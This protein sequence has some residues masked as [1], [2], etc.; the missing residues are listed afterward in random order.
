MTSSLG[1][2]GADQCSPEEGS[3]FNE[4]KNDHGRLLGAQR[5]NLTSYDGRGFLAWDPAGRSQPSGASD[6]GTL[7]ADLKTHVASAGEFGCGFE[8]QLEAW[9]RFLIDPE[10]PLEV[11]RAP[12]TRTLP[13][14]R[15]W[16]S[17]FLPS[18]QTFSGPI[19]PSRSS[20]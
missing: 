11:I 3:T 17:K 1:G 15:A 6:L 7:I 8:S 13:Y 2:H 12:T 9:Y 5:A 18:A 14:S 16:T 19:P 10:P 20:C 4:T